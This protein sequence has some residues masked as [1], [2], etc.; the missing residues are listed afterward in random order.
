MN[1]HSINSGALDKSEL[2]K[3]P[4][5][6]WIKLLFIIN[7]FQAIL[8][9]FSSFLIF[10]VKRTQGTDPMMISGSFTGTTQLTF[11][12]IIN[13]AAVM[14]AVSG[15]YM[16]RYDADRVEPEDPAEHLRQYFKAVAITSLPLFCL[17]IAGILFY[18]FN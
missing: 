15:Y 8:L 17:L 7:F 2:E 11:F 3:W 4:V 16:Y 14:Y 9:F 5:S 10:F 12:V 6:K 18:V 13:I 1:T